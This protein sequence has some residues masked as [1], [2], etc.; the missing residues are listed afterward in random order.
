M[1]QILHLAVIGQHEH[2]DR[3]ALL[4]VG[5]AIEPPQQEIELFQPF[6][7]AAQLL[8]IALAIDG[9]MLRPGLPARPDFSSRIASYPTFTCHRPC[10]R[11]GEQGTE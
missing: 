4:R 8:V 5:Y 9:E 10:G 3:A 7:K 2:L 1:G 11:M 6:G